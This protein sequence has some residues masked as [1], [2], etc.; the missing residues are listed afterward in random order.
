MTS[1]M[2]HLAPDN[3]TNSFLDRS[4][5]S[6]PDIFGINKDEEGKTELI[7]ITEVKSKDF[8]NYS[9]VVGRGRAGS[10]RTP[11]P[12]YSKVSEKLR[13]IGSSSP[14]VHRLQCGTF[15]GGKGCKYDNPSRWRK[16]ETGVAFDGLFSHW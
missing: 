10:S 4:P 14:T 1:K 13:Q 16:E 11:P 5:R 2:Q 7:Q 12:Q 6:A 8:L 15:C 3:S 9:P